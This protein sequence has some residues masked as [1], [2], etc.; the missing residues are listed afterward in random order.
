VKRIQ[1]RGDVREYR[2]LRTVQTEK[3]SLNFQSNC[4]THSSDI[5]TLQH[6]HSR[7]NCYLLKLTT[8]SFT[9]YAPVLWNTLPKHLCQPSPHQS[10]ITLTDS[11][12]ALSLISFTPNSKRSYFPN[13]F[14]L[15]LYAYTA[16]Y[17]V[18]RPASRSSSHCHFHPCH[19][20]SLDSFM[21]VSVN[22]N[23]TVIAVWQ[24]LYKH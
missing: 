16:S 13:H 9:H 11:P 1:N 24:A 23:P 5:V 19:S 22:K 21:P 14:H 8:R 7:M 10:F 2:S 3:H 20:S 15:S 17:L 12:L 18:S 4:L 6:P